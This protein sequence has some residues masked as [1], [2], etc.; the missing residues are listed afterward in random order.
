MLRDVIAYIQFLRENSAG[1][2]RFCPG[3]KP[4]DC[5]VGYCFSCGNQYYGDAASRAEHKCPTCR[6]EKRPYNPDIVPSEL[7]EMENLK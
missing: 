4:L 2:P 5:C 1:N 7:V 6:K 3:N